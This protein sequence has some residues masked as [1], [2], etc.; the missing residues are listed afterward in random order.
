MSAVKDA[1][2]AE[3]QQ[4]AKDAISAAKDTLPSGPQQA[5]KDAVSA[6]RDALPSDPKQAAKDAASTAKDNVPEAPK[7]NFFQNFF[8]G[9]SFLHPVYTCLSEHAL[10]QQTQS[11]AGSRRY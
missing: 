10:V 9:G 2:P 1:L 6:A 7:G 8:S 3:P 11:E 5:A 4:A